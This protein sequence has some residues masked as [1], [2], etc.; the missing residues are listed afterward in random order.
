MVNF[1][2][3]LMLLQINEIIKEKL[4]SWYQIPIQYSNINILIKQFIKT[5]ISIYF[6]R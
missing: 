6:M 1:I 2:A 3:I 5:W 4:Y